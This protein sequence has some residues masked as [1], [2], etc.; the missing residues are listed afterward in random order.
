MTVFFLFFCTAVRTMYYL[1][2]SMGWISSSRGNSVRKLCKTCEF[3]SAVKPAVLPTAVSLSQLT[4][5]AAARKDPCG[6]EE[7]LDCGRTRP[8]DWARADHPG[9]HQE[10]QDHPLRPACQ[11][12]GGWTQ[13]CVVGAEGTQEARD[14][15]CEWAVVRLVP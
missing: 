7:S 12:G 1:P 14:Q 11:E 10:P 15:R 4:K 13:E 6:G 8:P 5:P 9:R 3:S 2:S